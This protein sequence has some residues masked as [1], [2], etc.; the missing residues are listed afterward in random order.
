[1]HNLHCYLDLVCWKAQKMYGYAQ[2]ERQPDLLLF[3][4]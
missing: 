3:A 4:D 1:L 2:V